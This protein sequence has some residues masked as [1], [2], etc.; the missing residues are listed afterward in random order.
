MKGKCR[1]SFSAETR[2]EFVRRRRDISSSYLKLPSFFLLNARARVHGHCEQAQQ[3][4]RKVQTQCRLNW[5]WDFPSRWNVKARQKYIENF[6]SKHNHTTVANWKFTA[7]SMELRCYHFSAFL[8]TSQPVWGTKKQKYIFVILVDV[9]GQ[10][11]RAKIESLTVFLSICIASAEE[12]RQDL[13]GM[14]RCGKH[15]LTHW[16]LDDWYLGE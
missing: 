12:R 8:L 13:F 1:K 7:I 15:L 2:D 9:F 3:S 10:N 4:R 11:E 16:V 6:L 14:S 5:T